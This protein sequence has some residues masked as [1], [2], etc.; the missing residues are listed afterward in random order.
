M[1][2]CLLCIATLCNHGDVRLVGGYTDYEGRV[3]VCINGYWGHVC[4]NW[5]DSTR[6]LVVCKQLFGENIS[7]M[8]YCFYLLFYC[9]SI[10]VFLLFPGAVPF[11]YGVFGSDTGKNILY[12]ISCSGSPSRLVDCSYSLGQGYSFGGCYYYEDAGVRCYGML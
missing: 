10:C 7:K 6:A 4:D 9:F 12:S 5:L 3:E 11:S 2:G 8:N 1:F